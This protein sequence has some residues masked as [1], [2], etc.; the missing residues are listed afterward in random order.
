[1]AMKLLTPGEVAERLGIS[2]QMVVK[3][4][5][6]GRIPFVLVNGRRR[7]EEKHAR[8][9]APRKPGPKPGAKS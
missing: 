5:D 9:P 6:A 4:L 8:K 3:Y 2:R 1:M 7:I